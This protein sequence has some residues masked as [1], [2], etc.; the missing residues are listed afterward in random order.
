MKKLIIFLFLYCS[1]S[2]IGGAIAQTL[3]STSTGEISFYSSTPVEDISAVNKKV[4]SIMN[5]NT[6]EV[7]VQP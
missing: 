2:V 6:R 3:F 5:S 4:G 7:A 1:Q